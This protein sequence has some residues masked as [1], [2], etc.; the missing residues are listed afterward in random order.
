MLRGVRYALTALVLAFVAMVS[1]EEALSFQ[2]LPYYAAS[3]VKILSYF[4]DP[5]LWYLA[6]GAVM[7]GASVAFG[8]VWCR[9][10]CPLGGLYGAARRPP[11]R[12]PSCATPRRASSCQQ[13]HEASAT[14]AC[15][16]TQAASVRARRVRRL[17]GLR[18]RVS[19]R[20]ARSTARGV[21]R[22]ARSP[23]WVWPLAVVGAV[24]RRLRRRAASP[25]HWHSPLPASLLQVIDAGS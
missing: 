4:V 7:V 17:H 20:A 10:L 11:R 5:P 12:A 6:F 2:Q 15:A 1:A 8:N 19:R 22:A 23:W 14:R 3:D 16:S 18:D 9:Y 25:G 21:R 13:V 24:A